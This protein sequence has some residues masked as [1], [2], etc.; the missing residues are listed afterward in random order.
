MKQC[1]EQANRAKYEATNQDSD[2]EHLIAVLF[3]SILEL[4]VLDPV[5]QQ[6]ADYPS[7]DHRS[8]VGLTAFSPRK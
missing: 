6:S 2:E 3:P 1:H 4:V 5:G 7:A 8:S